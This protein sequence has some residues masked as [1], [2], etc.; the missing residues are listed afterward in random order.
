MT[1]PSQSGVTDLYFDFLCPYA[2]R[3]LELADVLRRGHG[4]K[5]RLRHFSLVQG[6]HAENPDRK[7][8]TGNG[9]RPL[10]TKPPVLTAAELA[11]LGPDALEELARGTKRGVSTRKPTRTRATSVNREAT[12]PA[13][14]KPRQARSPRRQA[15]TDPAS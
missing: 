7:H 8:P 15:G 2:W 4:L 13:K 10:S 11:T 12:D 3:G 14:A 6:N 1:L 9:R 5:F